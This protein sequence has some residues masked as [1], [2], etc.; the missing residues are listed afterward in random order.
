MSPPWNKD[1]HS[2]L[3]RKV[4]KWS[5]PKLY[6][7][8]S[9]NMQYN[10]LACFCFPL[11]RTT[12]CEA[13]SSH[14]HNTD[15][16]HETIPICKDVDKLNKYEGIIEWRTR[17]PLSILGIPFERSNASITFLHAIL[18]I[19]EECFPVKG[20]HIAHVLYFQGMEAYQLPSCL[21]S[22]P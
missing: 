7:V 3:T 9:H 12:P 4:M 15:G 2:E 16:T 11:R 10:I 1:M 14:L 8:A 17:D 13:C 18:A 22:I 21:P 6:D 5:R 19:I 20:K